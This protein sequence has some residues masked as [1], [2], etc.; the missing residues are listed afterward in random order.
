MLAIEQSSRV[1]LVNDNPTR[2]TMILGMDV[3]HGSP[4]RS[5]IPSIAA[6]ITFLV[7]FKVFA[8]LYRIV[9]SFLIQFVGAFR[10]LALEVGHL[11]QGIKQLL[12][13]NLLRWR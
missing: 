2:A 10:L 1:P 4:G 8:N 9:I 3:S 7:S 6:V 12:E 5:D 13:H 11:F